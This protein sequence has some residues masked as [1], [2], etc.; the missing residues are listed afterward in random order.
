MITKEQ[1]CSI[2]YEQIIPNWNSMPNTFPEFLQVFSQ[3]EKTSNEKLLD[4]II[5]ELRKSLQDFPQNSSKEQIKKVRNQINKVID[6]ENI[7]H[8]KEYISNELL[9]EFEENAE[10]FLERAKTFD[11]NLPMESIWQAMR[12]YLIYAIIVNLQR[13]H[14]NCQDTILGYSLL[15][16]YTDNYI[17][18]LH[19]K[20]IDKNS[21]N[22]LIRKTLSGKD[23][24]PKN[25][26]EEKTKQLI[27]LVLDHYSNYACKQKEA[28]RML[29]LMLEAQEKSIC[30]IHRFGTKRLTTKEILRISTYKG[31]LSVL[32]DYLFSIDFNVSSITDEEIYF[33][34]SFG[35]ILQLADD[36]QDITEDRKKHSQTLIT[37]CRYKRKLESTV[38]RL[39]HFTHGCIIGFSP[40]NPELHTFMLQNC[41]LMIL[42][43]VSQNAKYFSR[44]YLE[45]IEPHLPF[46]ISYIK[47]LQRADSF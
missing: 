28:S 12:N 31:G 24:C 15:Y 3:E 19:R 14:Q 30:Q 45:K 44:S 22:D 40:K 23:I 27:K 17:D 36:L 10:C 43:A 39:L 16:P 32:L 33:Y 13:E 26:Y 34:L 35:L 41:Q 5:P 47:K 18:E 37:I 8:I 42:A 25:D 7:L 38:N 11:E 46:S 4:R 20:D 21:Y 2:C 29:L 6:K 1:L 9:T